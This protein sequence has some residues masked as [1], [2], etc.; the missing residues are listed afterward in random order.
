VI[1]T[2]SIE[3]EYANCINVH[4]QYW[5]PLELAYTD[6]RAGLREYEQQMKAAGIDRVRAV[7]QQQLDE[8]VASL[9]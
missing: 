5:W 4:M 7:L 8:Y 6:I 2:S 3:T 1:D 9:K